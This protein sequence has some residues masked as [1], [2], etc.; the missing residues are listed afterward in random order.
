[1]ALTKLSFEKPAASWNQAFPLG[2][3]RLG[4]MFF[5]GTQEDTLQ[6]NEETLWSGYPQMD[7]DIED[8]SQILKDIRNLCNQ[9]KYREAQDFADKN[10]LG[11]WSA[12][13]LPAGNLNF[14]FSLPSKEKNY[15]RFLNMQEGFSQASF[16]CGD[17]LFEKTCF[18]SQK[19][20]AIFLHLKTNKK[21]SINFSLELTSPL[22]NTIGLSEN[23]IVMSGQTPISGPNIV[24]EGQESVIYA[25]CND[26]NQGVI[27]S[28]YVYLSQ[29][30]G[31]SCVK[32]NKLIVSD[33]SEVLVTLGVKTSYPY[34]S[35]GDKDFLQEKYNVENF[36]SIFLDHKKTFSEIFNRLSISLEGSDFAQKADRY[37][38]FGRYLLI[39]SSIDCNLPANLQGIWN[40]DLR[41]AWNG[42]YTT[43]INLEMNY[44]PAQVCNLSECENV[45][46]DFLKE[47]SLHGEKTALSRY[48]CRGWTCHHN[49]DA[50]FKTSPAGGSC[51]WALWPMGGA[52]L[53][54][55]I[56]DAY[57]F[58][59][60]KNFLQNNYEVLKG[61]T[62]FLLDFLTL[63]KDGYLGTCPSTSPENNFFDSKNNK[64][65]LSVSS[66][67]DISLCKKIFSDFIF[68][69]LELQKE[70]PLLE[71]V[72][73][74]L[75]KLPAIKV[76]EKGYIQEW[77]Q[78]FEQAEK[79]HRHFSHLISL[80][81][82][83][84]I[85]VQE[86]P[87]LAAA[88]KKS[89]E[90]RIRNGGGSTG[91]SA[92]WAASLYARLYDGENAGKMLE[93]LFKDF[94]LDNLLDLCPP[95]Q[96][97]GNFGGTAA[98]A[99]CLLQSRLLPDGTFRLDLLPALPPSWLSG[100]VCGLKARGNFTVDIFWK[101]KI[102]TCV[103]IKSNSGKIAKVFYKGELYD[104]PEN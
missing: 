80:Y 58:N 28:T 103:K 61:C 62:L 47:L 54:S 11:S 93:R 101:N 23:K 87:E 21:G 85:S 55:H 33:S 51:E 57:L 67:M 59:Q 30:D 20:N 102:L 52:W 34:K 69:A 65:C 88:A 79:G 76:S 8:K 73:E 19:E 13:Y 36:N 75:Q 14:S 6:F 97:D 16:E 90:G 71:K 100:N 27:F 32:D 49:S 91:W 81:P 72:K 43:N 83:F 84:Q 24:E 64:T 60:D 42:N 70:E 1:M 9:E 22:K 46:F 68:A 50:W 45:L 77:S 56:T 37:F 2:N 25:S 78:D 63:Q 44:W 7:N 53:C 66:A 40:Q 5:G 3:G 82:F 15:K 26:K 18:A 31:A 29:K 98:I 38:N 96:I 89:L 92:S 10:F 74:S 99:E 4:C 48:A 35:K 12:F 94:T 41:P 104:L 86:N 17:I 39:S 95:F